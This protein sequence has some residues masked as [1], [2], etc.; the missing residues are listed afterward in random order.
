M[1]A[2]LPKTEQNTNIQTLTM[3][4]IEVNPMLMTDS[5]V[6][7]VSGQPDYPTS[8]DEMNRLLCAAVVSKKFRNT[9]IRN[10]E[11][12]VASGYQGE[13]FNLSDEE[14]SWLYSNRPANLVD[15]AANMVAH[16]QESKLRMPV[17]PVPQYIRV[18]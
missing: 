14:R 6:P 10:P 16:Q 11:A 13:S 1:F 9:L 4:P 3:L 5:P 7:Q 17:E 18:N 2:R 15:L 12:A 8:N